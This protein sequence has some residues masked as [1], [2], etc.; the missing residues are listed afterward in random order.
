M[1]VINYEGFLS[2]INSAKRA[3]PEVVRWINDTVF[4]AVG[5]KTDETL[6]ALVITDNADK[7]ENEEPIVLTPDAITNASDDM[8][9]FNNSEYGEL[10]TMMING[11]PWF[12]AVDVCRALEI[13][14]TATRRLDD[15]EKGVYST[16]TLG[17][18]QEMSIV[19]E[20]GLYSLVLGSRKPEA[21]AFKRWI[22]H[23]VIPSLRKHG[24]YI[25]GQET[26]T[27]TELIAK[28]LIASHR[29][30][31]EMKGN[32]KGLCGFQQNLPSSLRSYTAQFSIA[33]SLTSWTPFSTIVLCFHFYC[34]ATINTCNQFAFHR[35]ISATCIAIT[36][37]PVFISSCEYTAFCA[38]KQIFPFIFEILITQL[39]KIINK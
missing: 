38:Y 21:K 23:D 29:I 39:T 10:R 24:A 28:A 20:P 22:T 36:L 4:P 17:G 3:D 6:P 5:L 26:M 31:E 33:V 13:D 1:N 12:V 2:L 18:K 19:N 27:E 30:A 37:S 7:D 34:F 15:D 14:R 8:R 9:V 16:H 25:I 32:Q 35:N 11:E